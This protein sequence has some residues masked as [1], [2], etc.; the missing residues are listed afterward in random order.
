MAQQ[1]PQIIYRDTI[2]LRG[3]VYDNLGKPIKKFTLN[4]ASETSTLAVF[5]SVH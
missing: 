2:N 5:I 1:E 4:Q 3:Y